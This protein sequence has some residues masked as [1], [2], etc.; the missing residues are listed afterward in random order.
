MTEKLAVSTRN[1]MVE[2]HRRAYGKVT[3]RREKSE[4]ISQVVGLGYDRKYA[5]KLLNGPSRQE[6][7]NEPR[8]RHKYYPKEVHELVV[9]VH[10]TADMNSKALKA[11]L[12][13]WL[14]SVL[15][16]MPT[17]PQPW[18]IERASK[19]SA[20]TIDRILQ[21]DRSN[22]PRKIRRYAGNE[23]TRSLKQ[24]IPVRTHFDKDTISV[25]HM[26][27]D[28]VRHCGG[29]LDQPH[30]ATLNMVDIASAW[31]EFRVLLNNGSQEVTS[32]IQSIRNTMPFELLSIDSDNGSEFINHTLHRYCID[33]HI[34]Q[35]RCRPYQKND[36]CYVEQ[37]NRS[38][39]RKALTHRRL[40]PEQL[41]DVQ[42]LLHVVSKLYNYFT[43]T[44]LCTGKIHV[45]GQRVKRIYGKPQ[46]PL[47]RLAELKPSEAVD[48]ALAERSKLN[49][50]D[51]TKQRDE[52]F[53]RICAYSTRGVDIAV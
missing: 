51:L 24:V 1:E 44:M 43:P 36:Q 11:S 5:I 15:S 49:P 28:T 18:V 33:Q 27:I 26:E 8:V 7:E 29:L 32:R 14:P 20:S 30:L 48:K 17:P 22:W 37:K 38:I 35:T 12:G 46:T 21:E 2:R 42:Q 50:V 13:I 3:A 19:V 6:K 4:L 39:I 10:E 41:S 47:D 9:K 52:L 25:G 16:S 45:D 53:D 40:Q 34:P 31:C 23:V